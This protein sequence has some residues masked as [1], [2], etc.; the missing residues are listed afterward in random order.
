MKNI[1]ILSKSGDS[2][3]KKAFFFFVNINCYK[4][5]R[6]VALSMTFKGLLVE[7]EDSGR[8]EKRKEC[9]IVSRRCCTE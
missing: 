4:K 7:S 2:Y 5:F 3:F 9:L 8:Y 1:K 6:K